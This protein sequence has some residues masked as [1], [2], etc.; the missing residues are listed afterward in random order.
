MDAIVESR[1]VDNLYEL[2]L[3]FKKQG[4]DTYILRKFGYTDIPEADMS[5][6]IKCL[7]VLK[8]LRNHYELV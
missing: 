3:R 2:P 6:W 4:L 5:E 1:N 8:I 7:S